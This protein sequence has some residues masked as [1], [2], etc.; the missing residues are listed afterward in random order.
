MSAKATR[1]IQLTPAEQR[2]IDKGFE[3]IRTVMKKKNIDISNVIGLVTSEQIAATSG[4]VKVKFAEET[5]AQMN[6]IAFD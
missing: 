5:G 4:Q 6:M 3:T 2:E 1:G